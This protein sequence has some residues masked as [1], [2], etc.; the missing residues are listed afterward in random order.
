MK[1]PRSSIARF[2]G[3][4]GN[5]STKQAAATSAPSIRSALI[6]AV[7]LS[8][9]PALALIIW[10]GYEHGSH[11]AA[12]SRL[13]TARQVES[14]ANLQV[15]ITEASRQLL[16]TIAYLPGVRSGD[17]KH[18]NGILKAVHAQNPE[19]LNF[20]MVDLAG[21]VVASS[22]LDPG[23]ALRD[24]LHIRAALDRKVFSAGEYILGLVDAEPSFTFAHPVFGT[25]GALIGAISATFKLSSY[26]AIFERLDLPDQ[27]VLGFVDRNGTR[28][29]YYPPKDTNPLGQKIKESVWE[30]FQ[31][32]GDTG[33]FTEQ[34]SDGI[35]RY[36]SYRKLSTEETGDPYLYVV[37]AVPTE[38]TFAL[39]RSVMI[40]NIILMVL[41]AIFA[42]TSSGLISQRMFG[43]R[44][45]RIIATANRLQQGELGARVGFGE[46]RSDLG[47][48]AAAL[49]RMAR[50]LELREA[51]T[52]EN[53]KTLAASL[54][55]KETLLQE[56][57]HRVKNNLQLIMSLFSL[58]EDE[59]G[60]P[61]EF[62]ET[63]ENRIKAMSMVHEM[64]YES[65]DFGV[66]D[67]GAYTRRL[68]D[69]ASMSAPR[70]WRW[71]WTPTRYR[72]TWIR[73][74]RTGCCSTS[75]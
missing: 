54:A 17:F 25:G 50:T 65:N 52:A 19:Y 69:L 30:S 31:A 68:V 47:Q 71:R 75:W 16:S 53:A 2:S 60:S 27:A 21:I 5:G 41:V 9:V 56:V 15:R 36:Y 37:Y 33:L 62:K 26:K 13:E 57:H 42:L 4:S 46:D 23:V 10:T 55:E 74:C 29:F 14:F 43:S 20:T 66:I 11:L 1:E 28:L 24:R 12:N 67:L 70:P 45:A 8:M 39:S 44:L 48:I 40:R 64:L 51:E 22:R 34:G 18:I 73:R 59:M 72:A 61:A 58:Q 32:G 38:A 6:V 3:L 35:S 63:M 7:L 49:D